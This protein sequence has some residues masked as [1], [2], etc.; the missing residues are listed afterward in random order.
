MIIPSFRGG[1]AELVGL[2]TRVFEM[3]QGRSDGCIPGKNAPHRWRFDKRR[4]IEGILGGGGFN[5]RVVVILSLH[6][7]TD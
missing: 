3:L 1:V 6:P 2:T 4:E 5:Y 7:W